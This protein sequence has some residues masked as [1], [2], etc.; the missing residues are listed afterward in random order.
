M[1]SSALIVTTLLLFLSS[2]TAI[3]VPRIVE[4]DRV[5]AVVDDN[6]ITLQELENRL[7]NIKQRLTAD[8]TRLPPDDLLRR[9]VLERLIVERLQL[10]RAERIGIRVDD[11]TVN[12]AIE[13]VARD[14][15]LSLTQFREV[16]ERDGIPFATFREQIRDEMVIS[17]LR[18]REVANRVTV[19]PREVDFLLERQTSQQ[20]EGAEYHL[21]HILV[22]TPEAPTPE[23][24]QAAR[25]EAEGLVGRLRA[26]EDFREL[27]VAHSDGQQALEGGDLGWRRGDQLPTL[28]ADLMADMQEG[29]VSDPIRSSSGFHII[30]LEGRRGEQRHLVQQTHARH[31]L[32]RTDEL[33]S[34]DDARSRLA[35]LRDRVISGEDFA[36]LARTHS[37]DPGST[38]KGGDL[39]W[40]NP[41]QF[42]PAFEKA[43]GELAPGQISEP[44]KS[45]F[46]W[47]IVQVLERRDYDDTDTFLRT[48]AHNALRERK[49][50][51]E[52]QNWL[53]RLRD[54]A[55]VKVMLDS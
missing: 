53:R 35:R 47:H 3:G 38:P 40:A 54:E 30:R 18:A 10:D 13:Q 7:D 2:A 12:R 55:Y 39:G 42:V 19:S 43:L 45:D 52:L 34:D 15:G 44:F 6:V 8:N 49:V 33:T 23:Q 46:G 36:K 50:E 32:I 24:V 17:R 4:L 31:I 27:A 20:L 5:V 11:E 48:R 29:D 21:S 28:F 51:E 41:G 22:A 37:Q 25:N 16:L 14:N 9:Q 26:G 1:K